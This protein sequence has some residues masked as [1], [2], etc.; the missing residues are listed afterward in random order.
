[1][2]MTAAERGH[3]VFG[4]M[5][6]SGV[7]NTIDRIIDSFPIDEQQQVRTMIAG[8]LTGI[9][10]LQL[11]PRA[12]GWG[13]MPA[14]EILLGTQ[15]ICATIREGKTNQ[16]QSIMQTARA[17]GMQLMDDDIHRLLKEGKI[18]P[19][20]AHERSVDKRIFEPYLKA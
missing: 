17:A 19:D 20:T 10:G 18:T 14:V 7:V 8:T 12:D 9:A 6:T 3:C 2:A 1:M 5:N 15:A 11:L 16:I 13:L 4:T